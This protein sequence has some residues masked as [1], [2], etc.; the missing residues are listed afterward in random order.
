MV[1]NIQAEKRLKVQ[2]N[3]E[4]GNRTGIKKRPRVIRNHIPKPEP[5]EFIIQQNK[6]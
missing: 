2:R 6:H 4:A 1:L 5:Q 3:Y